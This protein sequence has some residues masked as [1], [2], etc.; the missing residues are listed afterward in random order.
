MRDRGGVLVRLV[1]LLT[2]VAMAAFGGAI[3]MI[4]V[5]SSL[6]DPSVVGTPS[7]FAQSIYYLSYAYPALGALA[8][9]IGL[10]SGSAS[11]F[12]RGLAIVD[13]VLALIA[14]VYLWPY[15]WVGLQ[16]WA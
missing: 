13:G 5:S 12:V 7:L 3:F 4:L 6:G 1:P 15:G 11:A 9:L 2:V 10:S 16:I 8:V 14:A